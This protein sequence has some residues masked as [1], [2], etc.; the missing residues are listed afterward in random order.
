MSYNGWSNH[1]TWII[2]IWFNP[3]TKA[4][5]Q[6]IR[7]LIE[8]EYDKLPGYMKDL[9]AV[10]EIN[11]EELEDSLDEEENEEELEKDCNACSSDECESCDEDLSNWK[12]RSNRS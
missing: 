8:E 7:E 1:A 5:V 10:N 3:E 2:N 12:P 9:S 4:D 6:G 11:W